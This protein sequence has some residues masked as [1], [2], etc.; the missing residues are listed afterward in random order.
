MSPPPTSHATHEGNGD[1]TA[2]GDSTPT[3]AMAE[4]DDDRPPT[5]SPQDL[6]RPMTDPALGRLGRHWDAWTPGIEAFARWWTAWPW[7]IRS[8]ILAATVATLA[9]AGIDVRPW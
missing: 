4:P 9:R 6:T 2:D 1:S 3:S 5:G 8:L 7:Q